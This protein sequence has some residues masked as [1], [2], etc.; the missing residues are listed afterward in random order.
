M[1]RRRGNTVLPRIG[2]GAALGG[3]I[4]YLTHQHVTAVSQTATAV[5]MVAGVVAVLVLPRWKRLFRFYP[6]HL[7]RFYVRH[8]VTGRKVCG[9]IGL[10]RRDP[11]VRFEEHMGRG[12]YGQPAKPWT[13][14]VTD[15]DVIWSSR[16]VSDFGLALREQ[17]LI[18]IRRPLYNDVHNRK[19][20]RRV[21]PQDAKA[22]RLS[23]DRV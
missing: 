15:W 3:A 12:R 1:P 20:R 23:R 22:Q 9:Y 14:T 17:A 18:R 7:Y 10:T 6:G 19:N 21:M 4:A 2:L 8:P 5:L 11:R 16:R 13:D